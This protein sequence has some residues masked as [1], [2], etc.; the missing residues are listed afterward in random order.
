MAPVTLDQLK[1]GVVETPVAPLAGDERVGAGNND[2][3]NKDFG[4]LLRL[5]CVFANL[6]VMEWVTPFFK[7]AG[8][9]KLKA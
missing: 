9:G 5:N 4:V 1:V 7:L 8:V 3:Q 2:V 6:T